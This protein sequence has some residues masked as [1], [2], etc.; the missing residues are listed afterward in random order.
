MKILNDDKINTIAL[1]EGEVFSSSYPAD[2][3]LDD[4]PGHPFMANSAETTIQ[5]T[6]LTGIKSL[7]LS[8]L[9]ADSATLTITDSDNSLTF[10]QTLNTEKFSSLK[11]L[12]KNND[13]QISSTLEP[14]TIRS[15]DNT[16][17]N[18]GDGSALG[19][20]NISIVF[21]STVNLKDSPLE[22]NNIHQWNQGSGT[23][24]RFEDS[25]GDAINCLNH[26]NILVGSLVSIPFSGTVLPATIST[27]TT[28]SGVLTGATNTTTLAAD[29]TLGNGES[30]DIELVLGLGTSNDYQITK[31]ISDGTGLNDVTLTSS[32]SDSTIT[33][34]KNPIKLGILRASSVI[35]FQNPKVGLSKALKD[36]SIRLP[37]LNGGYRQTQRNVAKK[38][39]INLILPIAE[40][41]NLF[42]FY[43]A[44]R[45]KPFP[46]NVLTDM[47][48][49]QSEAQEYSCFCYILNAPE[50][51][52]VSSN[53][54]YVNVNFNICEVI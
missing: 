16:I 35:D 28:V 47:P 52:S 32:V 41:N 25:S 50:T 5:A 40:A 31:I 1:T 3:V 6:I 11:W 13:Q 44:F 34:I 43:R 39:N 27:N 10:N 23:S 18:N 14:Y 7:F 36:F 17:Q 49:S 21:R 38:F 48:S 12:A 45:S 22:G 29:L 54:D 30:G 53:G 19:A 42:D 37:L 2:N 15:S 33:A 8:N 51:Q 20:G 26:A 46:I 4:F 9:L 24:G